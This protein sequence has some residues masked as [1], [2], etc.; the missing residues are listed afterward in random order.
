MPHGYHFYARHTF[1]IDPGQAVTIGDV[2][3]QTA[4]IDAPFQSW[5]PIRYYVDRDRPVRVEGRDFDSHQ[6]PHDGAIWV[7]EAF[8]MI[9]VKSDVVH[10]LATA[11]NAHAL[12]DIGRLVVP[13]FK[14]ADQTLASRTG[15]GTHHPANP[16]RS[17]VASWGLNIDDD[18]TNRR[19]FERGESRWVQ[20]RDNGQT[21]VAYDTASLLLR[22]KYDSDIEAARHAWWIWN[23]H[24]ARFSQPYQ[25]N[26]RRFL[27][28]P[29]A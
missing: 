2:K 4:R 20:F 5:H 29:Q 28:H 18:E 7:G 17:S 24:F 14:A 21:I 13:D 9:E 11:L 23:A 19:E 10:R 3:I 1:E 25:R 8:V 6:V 27:R 22:A 16:A 26:W 12:L 15:R